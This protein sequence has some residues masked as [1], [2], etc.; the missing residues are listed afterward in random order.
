MKQKHGFRILIALGV[1]LLSIWTLRPTWLVLSKPLDYDKPIE[2]QRQANYKK[3]NPE[4]AKSAMA[5]GLDLAGGTHIVVEV[6]DSKL[7]EDAKKDVLDRC[8]EILRNRVD[9]YGVSEPVINKSGDNR[10]IAELA[11]LDADQARKLIGATALLEFKLVA[12]PEEF[13]PAL[14]RIDNYIKKKL[15]QNMVDTTVA[16]SGSDTLDNVVSLF[17]DVVSEGENAAAAGDDTVAEASDTEEEA[18]GLDSLGRTTESAEEFKTRPFGSLLV[19]LNN[20]GIGVKLE[21][22]LKAKRILNDPEIKGLIP[23]RYHFLWGKEI[24]DIGNGEKARELFFL[25]RRAEM[26]GEYIKDASWARGPEGL[27]VLLTFKGRGPKEFS[28]ITGA[29]IK[30]KL[31][32]VLDSVVYSAPVIQG[33]IT[34]GTASITGNFDVAEV[35]LLSTTLR[36]GSLPAPMNIVELRS[37]GPTLGFE[38][39]KK[40]FTAAAWG[41]LLVMLFMVLYYMGA[42]LIANL[43]L[44]FNIFIIGAVLSMFH[45]TL[46]LPGIAGIILT[47]GMAVDANVIIYERIREELRAKR[48]IRGAIDAGYKRAFTAIFDSNVTT[49][50]TAFILYYIGSGPIRGFGLTL[51]IGIA[52][53]MFTALFLT[54]LVFNIWVDRVDLKSLSIGDG[55]K[56][57]REPKWNL[58]GR[59]KIWIMGSIAVIVISFGIEITMNHFNWGIDFT[60]GNVFQVK[61]EETP[62]AGQIR[63]KLTSAGIE[64][65]KVQTVGTAEDKEILISVET[66][67]DSTIKDKILQ[68]VPE[69]NIIGEESV[70]PTIGAELKTDALL[71]FFFALILIV[72]YI[73]VR[74][75]KNGL[76]FGF[77]AVVALFHDVLITWGLFGVFGL[78]ISLTFVAAVLTIVGYSLNDTIIIFDRVRENIELSGK[79]GLAEKFNKGINQSFSRTIITSLTTLFVVAVLAIFGGAG[80]RSFALAMIMGILVGTY[81][82]I[83]I[84]APFVIWWDRRSMGKSVAKKKA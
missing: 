56:F 62:N 9:Q 28:R 61:F 15:G 81:S 4:I 23:R 21:D 16:Q 58:V 31:A 72:L 80:I 68:A 40:G 59:S 5:L 6:D 66:S 13:K 26:T 20:G 18:T 17:G 63:S 67:A 8:L 64:N 84:A 53:S 27:E 42:G 83:F 51:M 60:G 55:F 49:F 7:D 71:S 30:R 12:E 41:L 24:Q 79:E 22:I 39:I 32:I 57:L 52:A 75:G 48:S 76:G 70:G 43:A 3:E 38:N 34:Q 1:L 65:P 73:W 50:G 11:G 10:I 25:K 44:V 37:V 54:R 29:N 77:A 14:D 33:K 78:E 36:A 74:F 2:Q 69:G 47:I 35:K 46:T 45:A 19:G 82:S